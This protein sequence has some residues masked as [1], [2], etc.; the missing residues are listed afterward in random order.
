MSPKGPL[1]A[2]LATHRL[3][4][5]SL[6]NEPSANGNNDR[7]N[8]YYGSEL[9]LGC[10]P[11]HRI[12]LRPNPSPLTRHN[13]RVIGKFSAG[14]H[15]FGHT[16]GPPNMRFGS[17]AACPVR[18]NRCW[19]CRSSGVIGRVHKKGSVVPPTPQPRHCRLNMEVEGNDAFFN[20]RG[21]TYTTCYPSTP[22]AY[23]RS[24]KLKNSQCCGSI[25]NTHMPPPPIF[26]SRNSPF[27]QTG[28]W[29]MATTSTE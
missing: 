18:F 13:C 20:P 2:L 29:C 4:T 1:E 28:M 24:L 15:S 25:S 3:Y 8:A 5:C 11:Q 22:I 26:S 12:S 23:A 6:C 21:N 14:N 27:Y 16:P 19:V 10:P 17:E 7:V 9:C